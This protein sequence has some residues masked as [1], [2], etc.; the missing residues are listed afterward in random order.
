MEKDAKKNDPPSE[1]YNPLKSTP[2]VPLEAEYSPHPL[3]VDKS[4]TMEGPDRATAV[5]KPDHDQNSYRES[6]QPSYDPQADP[7]ENPDVVLDVNF[8]D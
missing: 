6:E 7:Y 4:N 5:P 8:A 2:S 1:K 3:I